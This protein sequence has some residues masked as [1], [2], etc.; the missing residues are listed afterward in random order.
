MAG[1]QHVRAATHK[2]KGQCGGRDPGNERPELLGGWRR[3]QSTRH[4]TS[5]HP[6]QQASEEQNNGKCHQNCKCW[7]GHAHLLKRTR[8]GVLSRPSEK[9]LPGH[10]FSPVSIALSHLSLCTSCFNSRT[11]RSL[12]DST[13]AA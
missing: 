1:G 9:F 4:E 7:P 8:G 3:L 6:A 13:N 11:L 12:G 5:Y 10:P 2:Q